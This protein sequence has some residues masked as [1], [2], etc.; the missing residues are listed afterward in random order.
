MC[1]R[2]EK[3]FLALGNE[4]DHLF[5]WDSE[6]YALV[7]HETWINGQLAEWLAAIL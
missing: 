5:L 7:S 6:I 4:V 1:Q 3:L 2:E